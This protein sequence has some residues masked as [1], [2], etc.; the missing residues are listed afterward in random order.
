MSTPVG[1]T[2]PDTA[3]AVSVSLP[4]WSDNVGYEEGDQKII[5]AMKGGY[6][7]FVFHPTVKKLFNYCL[8][9]F[10][11]ESESVLILNSRDACL[12][13]RQFIKRQTNSPTL[14]I[15][16]V[17]LLVQG[18]N[19][20]K[21]SNVPKLYIILFPENV[22]GTA[23]QFWQHT[24]TGISSRFAEFCLFE[25]EIERSFYRNQSKPCTGPS[26]V[27]SHKSLSREFDEQLQTNTINREQSVFLEERFGRNL[28][29]SLVS[30]ARITLK[31]RI[32]GVLGDA[33]DDSEMSKI[34]MNRS[35]NEICENHVFLFPSGMS[36]I[37]YSH[38]ITLALY[39]GLKSVQFG[40]PYI[41]TLKLQEKFGSGCIFYGFG[42][43][44]D[45]NELKT[46]LQTTHISALYCEFPSNP[47]LVSPPIKELWELANKFNF[48]LIIDETIGNFVNI[49]VLPYCHMLVSSLTKI[50]S[51]DS[52][53]MGGSLVVNPNTSMTTKIMEFVNRSYR[54]LV[55]HDDVLFLERNSRRFHSRI[56]IINRNAETICD[57]L[58][59]H[60]KGFCF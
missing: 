40:F 41:D 39:P 36:A 19:L 33:I 42:E 44:N 23:K 13:C 46:L 60:P 1:L 4:K 37:Y 49:N 14:K 12:E 21:K 55:W 22:S 57:L 58:C 3:H 20:T 52:N 53:V 47:L 10:G 27:K 51:G 45:L 32:A 6:P 11:T 7:R 43:D 26:D 28:D 35:S 18:S 15:R 31:K 5:K 24:G 59:N 48:I 34:E 8:N 38:Q 17:E 9:Q 2:I 54:D 25:L 30:E 56:D 29:V 50:F 16:L